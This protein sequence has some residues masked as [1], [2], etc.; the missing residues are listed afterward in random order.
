[1]SASAGSGSSIATSTVSA[2]MPRQRSRWASTLALPP[3][4]YVPSSDGNTSAIRTASVRGRSGIA[5]DLAVGLEG[6]VVGEHLDRAAALHR[7]QCLIRVVD[8]HVLDPGVAQPDGHIPRALAG[9]DGMPAVQ[10]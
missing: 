2:A 5:D 4:P 1:M 6:A 9:R 10:Q 8:A 7:A 3:S